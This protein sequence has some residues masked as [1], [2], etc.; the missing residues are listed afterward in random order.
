MDHPGVLVGLVEHLALGDVFRLHRALGKHPPWPPETPTTVAR[1]MGLK[2]TTY[3]MSSL[4]AKM[5]GN[6]RR[7]VW[8]G[9][10]TRCRPRVCVACADDA[11]SPYAMCTRAD[12]VRRNAA[13]AAPVRNLKHKMCSAAMPVA[14]RGVQGRYYYWRHAAEAFLFGG[15]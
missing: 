11:R 7:C 1:R 10:T 5:R 2:R 3:T 9:A 13:R 4:S 6:G 8:C 14:K 12:L 15:G